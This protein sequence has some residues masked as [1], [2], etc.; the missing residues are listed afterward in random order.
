MNLKNIVNIIIFLCILS[1]CNR[2]LEIY[3]D[4]NKSF[5][6]S[7]LDMFRN[8]NRYFTENNI[9]NY[10]NL[11]REGFVIRSNVKILTEACEYSAVL[12]SLNLHDEIEILTQVSIRQPGL[13]GGWWD[14][15]YKIKFK[16]IEG[17]IRTC[18][19][20][21]QKHLFNI[22]GNSIVIYPKLANGNFDNRGHNPYWLIGRRPRHNI[23]INNKNINLPNDL[24]FGWLLTK[25]ELINGNLHLIYSHL[26]NETDTLIIISAEGNKIHIGTADR[27]I[28]SYTVR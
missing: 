10:E 25:G 5:D 11:S 15:F 22:N 1:S 24:L 9:I 7:L 17:Y 2:N 23:F 12:G 18:C 27:I 14:S 8:D 13:L 3:A 26:I 20:D 28:T 21:E 16:N 6:Y 4:I 19:A